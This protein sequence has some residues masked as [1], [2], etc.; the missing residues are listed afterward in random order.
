MRPVSDQENVAVGTSTDSLKLW[1]EYKATGDVQLRNRLVVT[2]TPLV[3]YIVYKKVRE[4]PARCDVEDF[5]SCGLEALIGAIDR[6][7]PDRGP[8]LQQFA[9]TRIR[10][11]VLD[12]LRRQDWVPR[13]LRRWERSIVDARNQFNNDNGRSPSEI[14]LASILGIDEKRLESYENSISRTE[15]ISLNTTVSGDDENGSIERIDT[16]PSEDDSSDPESAMALQE[17]KERFRVAFE[18]LSDRERQV[19]GMLYAN[20][21]TLREIGQRLEVSESRVCQIHLQLKRTLRREL[22][23]DAALFAAVA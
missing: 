11:A 10:G 9:W 14:E 16:L 5:I 8:T 18:H 1:Q 7:D 22:D 19:A 20:D 6:Y 17:A 4:L 2:F 15:L 3:K 13:S 21:L 12:E 23:E